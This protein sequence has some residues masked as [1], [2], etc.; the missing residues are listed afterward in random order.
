VNLRKTFCLTAAVVM[1]L[2]GAAGAQPY[3]RDRGGRDRAVLYEFPNFQGRQVV[4]EGDTPNLSRR[5]F[6]DIAQSARLEGA[7]R[8]CEHSDY[9]GRCHTLEGD[10]ADLN[11]MQLGNRL[12]SLQT[13]R[14]YER[15]DDSF[16]G[17]FDDDDYGPG[18]G[19][20]DERGVA[21][22][23]SVFFPRPMVRGMDLAAGSNGANTFC[24]SKGLGP[25]VYFDSSEWAPRAVAPDGRMIGGSSVLRD[26]LCRRY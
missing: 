7:W 14:S 8:L 12:S 21:G 13:K 3:G 23:R 10:I 19:R 15:G 9:E 18:R 24:R 22:A 25:A 5:G 6:N 2:A 4:I 16:G 17:L 11:P 1:A 26:V 20:G